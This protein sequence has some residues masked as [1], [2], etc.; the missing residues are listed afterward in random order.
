MG[1]YVIWGTI[2]LYLCDNFNNCTMHVSM[3][4]IKYDD[5]KVTR[6]YCCIAVCSMTPKP[7]THW[8][9]ALWAE[10][11]CC[12]PGA[13]PR[14]LRPNHERLQT[15]SGCRKQP[16]FSYSG[17]FE[18]SLFWYHP[19]GQFALRDLT[20][21]LPGGIAPDNTGP[22]ITRTHETFPS[23]WGVES[24]ETHFSAHQMKQQTSG[25]SLW[26]WKAFSF[27]S[28]CNSSQCMIFHWF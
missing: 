6:Q 15:S 26:L 20:L 4:L 25:D 23:W 3:F 1:L 18:W 7:T 14:Y 8:W 17:I 16:Q 11:P 27:F 2:V 13:V 19:W 10:V 28:N 5:F 12:F 24:L 9:W 22:K 21:T